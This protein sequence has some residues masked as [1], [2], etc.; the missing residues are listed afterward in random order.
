MLKGAQ[1]ARGPPVSVPATSGW[2]CPAWME[3]AVP[4][5]TTPR[6]YQS[7]GGA[8]ARWAGLQELIFGYRLLRKSV[9]VPVLPRPQNGPGSSRQAKTWSNRPPTS[10][11]LD[12]SVCAEIGHLFL[13]LWS[14]KDDTL[15][16]STIC[17]HIEGNDTGILQIRTN[18]R[19]P[20]VIKCVLC[21]IANG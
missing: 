15:D 1:C 20:M 18:Y 19:I 10:I 21:L 6:V 2:M 9:F 7:P 11:V 5:L 3:Q 16:Q 12:A 17:F 14:T 8:G 13:V 4:N